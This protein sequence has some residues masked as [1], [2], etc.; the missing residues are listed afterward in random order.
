MAKTDPLKAVVR[1]RLVADGM[2]LTFGDV[3]RLCGIKAERVEDIF[4]EGHVPH[5]SDALRLMRGLK[6][7]N[8]PPEDWEERGLVL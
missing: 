2:G 4:L 7:M 6:Q 8:I 3:G 1:L 5:V